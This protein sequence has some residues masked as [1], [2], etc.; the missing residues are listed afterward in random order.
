M[1][2]VWSSFV[3]HVGV[4]ILD[5]KLYERKLL[6]LAQSLNETNAVSMSS[7]TPETDGELKQVEL[8]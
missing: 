7:M 4:E 1:W 5:A 8:K 3:I 6:G 2:E